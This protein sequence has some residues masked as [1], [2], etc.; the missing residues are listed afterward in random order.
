MAERVARAFATG[1]R[2]ASRLP[3]GRAL[4]RFT[5]RIVSRAVDWETAVRAGTVVSH[6]IATRAPWSANWV[7]SSSVV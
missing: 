5:A 2:S 7:V 4:V 6:A 1:S 3:S